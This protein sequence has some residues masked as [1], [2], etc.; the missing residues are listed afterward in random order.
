MANN[1]AL[2]AGQTHNPATIALEVRIFGSLFEGVDGTASLIQFGTKDA[3]TLSFTR[4]T[5]ATVSALRTIAQ[6][7]AALTFQHP[8][9]DVYTVIPEPP[10]PWTTTNAK[11]SNGSWLYDG[12]LKVRQQ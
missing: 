12:E 1:P 8:E 6:S 7:G 4:R 9:G 5:W 3:F 2:I 11:L 10:T